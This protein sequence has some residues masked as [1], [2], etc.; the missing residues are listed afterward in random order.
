MLGNHG[1]TPGGGG[2]IPWQ[3]EKVKGRQVGFK[4]GETA[5]GEKIL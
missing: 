4:K 5:R 3:G 2:R 1:V